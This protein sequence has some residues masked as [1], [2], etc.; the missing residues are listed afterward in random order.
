[1]W[2]NNNGVSNNRQVYSSFYRFSQ[3][4]MNENIK[5][6]FYRLLF[7][8]LLPSPMD[9]PQKGP[10]IRKPFPCHEVSMNC[11]PWSCRH[12]SPQN[13][14]HHYSDVI[15]SA[16]VCQVIGVSIVCSTV[17]SRAEQRKHQSPT[18]LA[19][20]RGIHRWPANSQHKGPLTQKVIPF[21]DVI[22]VSFILII[23]DEHS[24]AYKESLDGGHQYGE[25]IAR[26]L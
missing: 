26:L 9:S 2:H 20:V 7:G 23:W 11:S 25:V 17:S 8:G 4:N 10:V 12:F 13:Y 6:P 15:M 18:P 24:V 14:L 1:M 16:M 21:D 3:A 22:I 19:F 5:A